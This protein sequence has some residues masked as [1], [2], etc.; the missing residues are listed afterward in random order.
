MVQTS[1]SRC[2]DS[3][4]MFRLYGKNEDKEGTGVSLV[5]GKEFFDTTF[6]YNEVPFSSTIKGDSVSNNI[7]NNQNKQPLYYVLYYDEKTNEIV[8]NPY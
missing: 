3:L 7:Q 8:F 1:F 6:Q 4:T 5:F 2:I